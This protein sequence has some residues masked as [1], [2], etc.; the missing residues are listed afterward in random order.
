MQWT[1][2][3]GYSHNAVTSGVSHIPW[4]YL[5]FLCSITNHIASQIWSIVSIL[6][7]SFFF[8]VAMNL[9]KINGNLWRKEQWNCSFYTNTHDWFD[10]SM[11]I[12]KWYK[13]FHSKSTCKKNQHALHVHT[14]RFSVIS[15]LALCY[16][17]VTRESVEQI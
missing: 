3:Q 1:Y 10:V 13:M 7:F 14:S 6:F 5:L 17:H 15:S 9:K 2:P 8:K 11:T 4:E 12:N 16:L